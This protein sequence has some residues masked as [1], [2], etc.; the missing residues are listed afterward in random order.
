MSRIKYLVIV[1]MLTLLLSPIITSYSTHTPRWSYRIVSDTWVVDRIWESDLDYD[2]KTIYLG[3]ELSNSTIGNVV[4]IV[5]INESTGE[6][7][8]GKIYSINYKEYLGGIDYDERTGYVFLVGYTYNS[9]T[10]SYDGFIIR[11]TNDLSSYT[12]AIFNKG[13]DELF[14]NLV[15]G[16]AGYI[17]CT[18]TL[19]YNGDYYLLIA[20]FDINLNLL[21]WYA[22]TWSYDQS[23]TRLWNA[24]GYDIAL[25]YVNEKIY[26]LADL[27]YYE[28]INGE[29][30]YSPYY[31]GL[32]VFNETTGSL[33]LETTYFYDI[34]NSNNNTYRSGSGIVKGGLVSDGNRYLYF[35]FTAADDGTTEGT[36]ALVVV[37]FD[38][39]NMVEV[40]RKIV[41]TAEY[42][43]GFDVR[44]SNIGE[45]VVAG[46]TSNDYDTGLGT[47]YYHQ[48]ALVLNSDG[49]LAKS[50][51]GGNA[52]NTAI[53]YTAIVDR[54]G[55]LMVGGY[56]A[57]GYTM[58]YY[59]VTSETSVT[60]EKILPGRFDK[61]EKLSGPVHVSLD[62]K[63]AVLD[64]DT[65]KVLVIKDLSPIGSI[66]G[67]V[68]PDALDDDTA[69]MTGLD[70]QI[71]PA[72][73]PI[74]EPLLVFLVAATAVATLSVFIAF[75]VLRRR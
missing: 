44:I 47:N 3:L 25:G 26:V 53:A 4:G 6:I 10:N 2:G 5:K 34:T 58:V 38:Y 46:I 43:W 13:Y 70:V 39:L 36:P 69:I 54:D 57:A 62:L 75:K 74:P 63:P 50:I 17:Y 55:Y 18:G 68:G 27:E 20:K 8:A 67:V 49:T 22:V 29:D 45:V 32:A 1:I 72:P 19:I 28:N 61:E 30:Y 7:L 65:P 16:P 31:A 9:T 51:I 60:M 41:A 66:N 35:T 56:V 14:Y 48:F 24:T 52:S 42:E 73:P 59:D 40:W 37:K 12:Y 23:G 15:V 33:E 11:A 71:H 64:G 21:D